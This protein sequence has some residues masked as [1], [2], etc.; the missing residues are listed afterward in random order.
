MS[1]FELAPYDAGRRGDYLRLF[2]DVWR[3][4]ALSGDVFDWWFDGN[5]IGSLRSVAVRA[6]EVV[7]AVG[8]SFF[9][10]RL[11]RRE[12][13]VEFSLHAVTASSA[14]GQGVFTALERGLEEQGLERGS[15]CALVFAN[16]ASKPI[17]LGRLGWSRIDGRRVWARPLRGALGRLRGRHSDWDVPNVSR[18]RDVRGVRRFGD[19]TD[20]LYERL[21]PRLGNH[22]VRDARY[23]NWRYLE[24]P[25]KYRALAVENGYAVLGRTERRGASLAL[26]LD[27]VA[28]PV[29]ARALLQACIEEAS[30]E[31]DALLVLPTPCLPR[32]LLARLGF[33]PTP[34]R[35]HFLGKALGAPLDARSGTWTISLG[36]TD[37]F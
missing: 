34:M 2:A 13:L 16:A 32:G 26:V 4:A 15:S 9:R 27:V 36:D 31:A 1:E 10:A 33:M 3:S 24:S 23:L 8:H 30:P 18:G 7:G 28:E 25:R 19:E 20:R 29:A 5:P 17:Y 14:R 37:F 12:H 35:L 11:G 22:L 21:A 6:G